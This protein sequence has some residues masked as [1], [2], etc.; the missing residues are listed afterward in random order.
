MR[1]NGTKKL[2]TDRLLLRRIYKEDAIEIYNGFINQ[3]RFLYYLNKEKRTLEEEISSLEM[4][5]EKN[6]N[7]DYY[8]W[9]ITLKDTGKIIGMIVLKVEE[10]N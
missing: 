4:I 8:N 6:K 10:V 9:V 7:E 2:E 3:E 1:H 5:D